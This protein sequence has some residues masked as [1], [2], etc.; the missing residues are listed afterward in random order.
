MVH[1][2]QAKPLKI[3]LF[4]TIMAVMISMLITGFITSPVC[5]YAKNK[6]FTGDI[7]PVNKKGQ[8][9]HVPVRPDA[10]KI[11]LMRNVKPAMGIT[12]SVCILCQK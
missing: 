9:F 10:A 5:V 8:D 2:K 4:I 3:L 6:K 11:R 7:K 12:A 1:I